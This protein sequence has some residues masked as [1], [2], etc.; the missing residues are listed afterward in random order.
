[1]KLDTYLLHVFLSCSATPPFTSHTSR[2]LQSFGVHIINLHPSNDLKQQ[3]QQRTAQGES[4]Y[5]MWLINTKSLVLEYF[6]SP[7]EQYAALSHMWTA[8][9]EISFQ[10]FHRLQEVNH[11]AGDQSTSQ[12]RAKTGYKKILQCC[13]LAVDEGLQ[14][15]WVDTCCIDKTSSAEL[16]ESINSMFTWYKYAT[17]CFTYLADVQSTSDTYRPD[18]TASQWYF[19]GWTLQELVAPLYVN[20]YNS[21]W[22]KLGTKWSLRKEISS[23]TGISE[24]DIILFDPAR[25]SVAQKMSWAA[26]R[27]TTR[28][29]D[30]AYCLL[31]LFGIHMPLLYG[32]GIHA[33]RRLQEE[34]LKAT[35]DQTI[36]AWMHPAWAEALPWGVLASSPA[37]FE[38][39]GQLTEYYAATSPTAPHL[40]RQGDPLCAAEMT[41]P[42][43]LGPLSQGSYVMTNTGLKIELPVIEDLCDSRICWHNQ[44]SRSI[45]G[46]LGLPLR[47]GTG[48]ERESHVV[49]V[50]GCSDRVK[51]VAMGIILSRYGGK[52]TFQRLFI[53]DLVDVEPTL[54][55]SAPLK[56]M[57]ISPQTKW[58]VPRVP[59]WLLQNEYHAWIFLQVGVSHKSCYILGPRST[60]PVQD[61]NGCFSL[62]LKYE[63]AA[64][65]SFK[66]GP[67][68][69]TVY[70]GILS[71]FGQPPTVFCSVVA[72][73]ERRDSLHDCKQRL[74]RSGDPRSRDGFW[75]DLSGANRGGI[76][77]M[78]F[79]TSK[80]WESQRDL[81]YI[82]CDGPVEQSWSHHSPA[83]AG[84]APNITPTVPRFPRHQNTEP[85]ATPAPKPR[86]N[87]HSKN[88]TPSDPRL[89]TKGELLQLAQYQSYMRS[90]D[91]LN[92][93]N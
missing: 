54:A 27:I 73:A 26:K 78:A 49:A 53:D 69:Y 82:T 24:L 36:F 25:S 86:N 30:M 67:L 65:I 6:T 92:T 93:Q 62:E 19:R 10:E 40:A 89:G 3:S 70:L 80:S 9:Q 79:D 1:M 23:I 72:G 21:Q 52:S 46:V 44:S 2:G 18:G 32:E 66:Y 5:I 29:E 76:T 59:Q 34:L 60:D 48:S 43:A 84:D 38:Q 37:S 50:L 16:S 71:R 42:P 11:S 20:F 64:A 57:T 39:C 28:V 74:G 58:P 15:A 83:A 14:Y 87:P 61:G 22:Q 77:V 63:A 75:T 68:Q 88:T 13:K 56:A 8:N 33:F 12:L 35:A 81:V 17:V 45:S 51:G 4:G 90:L 41:D 31:G 47:N 85:I 7:P 91:S 55:A